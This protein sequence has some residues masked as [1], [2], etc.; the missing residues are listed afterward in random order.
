M[1]NYIKRKYRRRSYGKSKKSAVKRA[2]VKR[3]RTNISRVAKRV[4]SRLAEKKQASV[5]WSSALATTHANYYSTSI[6][7]QNIHVLTP[8]DPASGGLIS[9]QQGTGKNQRVGNRIRTTKAV[10][11]GIACPMPLTAVGGTNPTPFIPVEMK[12][13]IFSLKSQQV[14]TQDQVLSLVGT[15][16]AQGSI[17]NAGGQSY[18]FPQS[19]NLPS[20]PQMVAPLNTDLINVHTVRTFKLG[21][22]YNQGT[23]GTFGGG[24]SNPNV[25]DFNYNI[26]F[27]IPLTKYMPKNVTFN[28]NSLTSTSR[29]LF[30]L[31]IVTDANG[32]NPVDY[33]AA[34]VYY[35]IPVRLHT[36]LDYEYTDM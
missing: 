6:M 24:S 2:L 34:G 36:F 33:N 8:T 14:E 35:R 18:G 23:S 22:Q 13:V 15:P 20:L 31:W 10:Y 9:I 29:Q 16:S 12:C 19:Y 26:K 27:R 17:F 11:H 25:A 4:I 5:S 7:R 28:D 32:C 3:S 30:A 1:V 21:G